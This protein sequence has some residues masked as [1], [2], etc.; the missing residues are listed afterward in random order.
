MEWQVNTVRTVDIGEIKV[1]PGLNPG[2]RTDPGSLRLLLADI[3][4]RGVLFPLV[5]TTKGELADGHRRLKCAK[6]LGIARLRV[7]VM[8]GTAIDIWTTINGLAMQ[9]KGK[10]WTHLVSQGASPFNRSFKNYAD[11]IASVAGP[12]FIVLLDKAGLSLSIWVSAS[13]IMSACRR[14]DNEFARKTL[15]W[16][17]EHKAQ[18]YARN[19]LESGTPPEVVRRAIEQNVDVWNLKTG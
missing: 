14:S 5:V 10:H 16:L 1:I 6:D 8:P 3:K 7:L 18:R 2:D 9:V 17:V 13:R 4:T 11:H 15:Y 12:E 19:M